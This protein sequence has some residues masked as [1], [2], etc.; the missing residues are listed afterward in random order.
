M[1][2]LGLCKETFGGIAGWEKGRR[3][4]TGYF[5]IAASRGWISL[6]TWTMERG[7]SIMYLA[8]L[9]SWSFSGS[10]AGMSS[11]R[12]MSNAGLNAESTI[13][14]VG[15]MALTISEQLRQMAVYSSGDHIL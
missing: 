4:Y 12:H 8:L 1:E 3:A 9:S 7:F 15:L 5:H 2:R 14:S 6:A 13:T 11:R 10:R